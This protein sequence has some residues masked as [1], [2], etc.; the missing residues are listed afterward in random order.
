MVI[1]FT[2]LT[3]ESS[4]ADLVSGSIQ[5]VFDCDCFRKDENGVEVSLEEM[6]RST[7]RRTRAFVVVTHRDRM[8]LPDQDPVE[9]D[10]RTGKNKKMDQATFKSA[11]IKNLRINFPWVGPVALIDQGV[12]VTWLYDTIVACSGYPT[13]A[14]NQHRIPLPEFF[15][16]FKLAFDPVADSWDAHI[17]KAREEMAD[18]LSC[19][20]KI[21][22]KAI[23]E[24]KEDAAAKRFGGHYV[25]KI[26]PQLDAINRFL[27]DL[28]DN[29]AQECLAKCYRTDL[30]SLWADTDQVSLNAKGNG[31]NVIKIQLAPD[32]RAIRKLIAQ[33]WPQE[34]EFAMYKACPSCDMV[35]VRPTGCNYMG[36]CGKQAGIKEDESH[37]GTM[38]LKYA[39]DYNPTAQGAVLVLNE[40]ESH[41]TRNETFAQSVY[42]LRSSY[43]SAMMRLRIHSTPDEESMKPLFGLEGSGDWGCGTTLHWDKMRVLLADELIERQLVPGGQDG[44]KVRIAIEPV[45]TIA[46]MPIEDF[47]KLK[48]PKLDQYAITFRE[49]GFETLACLLGSDLTAEDVNQFLV[50]VFDPDGKGGVCK[51]H[52]ASFKNL[53]KA[54]RRDLE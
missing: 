5:D 25:D 3:R 4:L 28:F 52:M 43:R 48:A 37:A 7:P 47:I 6:R 20:T 27:D 23:E 45:E 40:V 16:K 1:A 30:E 46:A 54:W 13:Q 50:A 14:S 11:I 8:V 19:A 21:I 42:L 36:V 49:N 9:I 41:K 15:M 34:S 51:V 38:N 35:Y 53:L 12:S 10:P 24:K 22:R 32:L 17:S 26:G 33:N 44:G 2:N 39:Y 29:K 18:A 31:L